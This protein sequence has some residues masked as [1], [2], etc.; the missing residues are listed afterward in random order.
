MLI[1]ED[2]LKFYI[3]IKVVHTIIYSVFIIGNSKQDW[4]IFIIPAS[5]FLAL[6]SKSNGSN[7]GT[8]PHYNS[9]PVYPHQI[10]FYFTT[11]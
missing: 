4:G 9:W 8:T 7:P 6:R 10:N 11:K 5:A 1:L 2:Y 3:T